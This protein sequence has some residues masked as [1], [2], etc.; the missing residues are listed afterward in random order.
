MAR[1]DHAVTTGVFH[2]EGKDVEVEN[3]VWVIGDEKECVVF[4]CPHDAKVLLDTIAG[5]EVKLIL[6]THGDRDHINALAEVADA[7]GAPVAL[8]PDDRFMWD[9]VLP[10]R[11]PDRTLTHGDE[12]QVA[13]ITLQVLHTPGHTPG[14]VSVYTDGHVFSGDVL[15]PGGPGATQGRSQ[16]D[17]PTLINSIRTHLLTLPPDTVVHTGHGDST[18]IGAEAP[19]LDEWIARG[20]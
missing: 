9:V 14:H 2:H 3:N 17:F 10:D 4:D 5:R 16:S 7:T 12:I 1:I 6:C 19:H 13:D 18:T 11:T 15:F 8:H 20:Y